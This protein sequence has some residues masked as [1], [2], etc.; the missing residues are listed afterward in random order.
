MELHP[1]STPSPRRA[2]AALGLTAATAIGLMMVAA[3][4]TALASPPTTARSL[5]TRSTWTRRSAR[6]RG[7]R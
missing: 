1:N 6:P 4:T 7:S 2:G 3:P 5:R